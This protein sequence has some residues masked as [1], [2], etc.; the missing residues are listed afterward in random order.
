MMA[1]GKWHIVNNGQ[2]SAVLHASVMPFLALN[3][4]IA[5]IDIHDGF[6][7]MA[8]DENDNDSSQQSGHC[9]VP[10]SNYIKFNLAKKQTRNFLEIKGQPNI[11]QFLR[12][13]LP[14]EP[15]KLEPR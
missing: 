2:Q 12:V 6:G 9:L 5:L 4:L 1:L 13:A 8:D 15:V 3:D 11:S 10:P 7:K 14:Q